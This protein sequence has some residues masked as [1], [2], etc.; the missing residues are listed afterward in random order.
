MNKGKEVAKDAYFEEEED[1]EVPYN[2]AD[3]RKILLLK[4]E[5]EHEAEA[6]EVRYLSEFGQEEITLYKVTLECIRIKK[7]ISFLQKL[8]NRGEQCDATTLDL[9]L[10]KVMEGY[11]TELDELL[12][13]TEGAAKAT[14]L[15]KADA[16]KIKKLYRTYAKV[17]H[18]DLRHK[19]PKEVPILKELWQDLA[20]AYKANDLEKME[21]V[22]E[23]INITFK[24][25][26]LTLNSL[27]DAYDID[28]DD[29]DEKINKLEEKINKMI[30]ETP[31]TYKNILATLDDRKTH[32]RLLQEQTANYL[33]YKE[34]LNAHL[35]TLMNKV[36]TSIIAE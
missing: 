18:P 9:H 8:L 24:S 32:H 13:K 27:H 3:Y 22:S 34:E 28:P 31:Y 20:N 5:L 29:L 14:P 25:F 2:Y 6:Y 30:N 1:F 7:A 33:A 19:I 36:V 11:Y 17:L 26:G 10:K 16:R 15:A 12:N 23:L 21:E 4:D 35:T